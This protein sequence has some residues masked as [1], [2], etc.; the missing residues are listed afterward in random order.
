MSERATDVLVKVFLTLGLTED[1]SDAYSALLSSGTTSA[2][3]LAR[4]I[5]IPRSTTY[6]ILERLIEWKLVSTIEHN[7]KRRY[8]AEN[9]NILQDHMIYKKNR[10]NDI[11]YEFRN[12][13][14]LLS[15]LYVENK[16]LSVIPLPTKISKG[17]EDE[18]KKIFRNEFARIFI[19]PINYD[20]NNQYQIKILIEVI[21]ELIIEYRN[22]IKVLLHIDS[23][24]VKE[25]LN[26]LE[27]FECIRTYDIPKS[28][29]GGMYLKSIC[30]ESITYLN[31]LGN[32]LT[33]IND[34]ATFK[35]ESELFDIFWESAAEL[36]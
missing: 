33:E 10:V 4:L 21:K 5:K 2:M 29:Y 18:I 8:R 17:V 11:E 31:F 16:G 15:K 7:G 28:I 20:D 6:E 22:N 35:I 34:K 14:G 36:T 13:L 32:K 26:T 19:F 23:D 1:H 25:L 9:P 3:K 30:S 12:E 27:D 24:L